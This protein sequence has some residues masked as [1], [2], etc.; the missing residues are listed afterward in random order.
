MILSHGVLSQQASGS[1]PLSPHS[2]PHGMA[3]ELR[4]APFN[5]ESGKICQVFDIRSTFHSGQ[6]RRPAPTSQYGVPLSSQVCTNVAQIDKAR[7]QKVVGIL[8]DC[9]RTRLRSTRRQEHHSSRNYRPSSASGT[10]EPK[11]QYALPRYSG[12]F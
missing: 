5:T 6:T 10:M 9:C 8:Q 12:H 2:P 1:Q 7:H 11:R 4:S 3:K